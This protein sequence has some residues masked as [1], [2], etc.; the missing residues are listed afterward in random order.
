MRYSSEQSRIVKQE[1][2]AGRRKTL[3][4]SAALGVTSAALFAPTA[5]A[6][7]L[8]KDRDAD[9]KPTQSDNATGHISSALQIL[10]EGETA[11]A[12]I[13]KLNLRADAVAGRDFFS[14]KDAG[15]AGGDTIASS[16]TAPHF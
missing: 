1:V 7:P 4:L 11:R 16:A 13:T 14:V 15:E 3:Y 10:P 2:P 12:I 9:N 5:Y 8:P 6:A